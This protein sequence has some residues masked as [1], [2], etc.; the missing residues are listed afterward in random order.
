MSLNFDSSVPT[1]CETQS[2]LSKHLSKLNVSA[3]MVALAGRCLRFF[4]DKL[5]GYK[6]TKTQP[7]QNNIRPISST[8]PINGIRV[9]EK[10][11]PYLVS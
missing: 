7:L 11:I 4:L 9:V 2:D 5:L 6:T 10:L 3:S 8:Q 1:F